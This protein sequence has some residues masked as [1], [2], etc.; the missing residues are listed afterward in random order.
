MKRMIVLFFMLIFSVLAYAQTGNE[1]QQPEIKFDA[2]TYDMGVV[3]QEIAM[4]SF[5]FKNAGTSDL[6]IEK[7]VPS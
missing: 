1:S 7:L 3:T 2:V 6:I 5:E 4:H